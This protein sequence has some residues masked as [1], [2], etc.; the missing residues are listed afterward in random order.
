MKKVFKKRTKHL[1]SLFLSMVMILST[2]SVTA[3]AANN[4]CMEIK[5]GI[6]F[7][8]SALANN[9]VLDIHAISKSNGA[10]AEI[11]SNN[12]GLNQMYYISKRGDHY[13]IIALHSGK[14]IDVYGASKESGTNVCQ[15]E[16]N[17]SDIAE[18]WDIID[19]GNGYV[20]F[21]SVLG[22][23]LDVQ[24]GEV[25]DGA[26]VWAHRWNGS[27]A[28]QWLL[29]P[30]K[31]VSDVYDLDIQAPDTISIVPGES[32]STTIQFSG[33]GIRDFHCSISG[34]GL[35]GKIAGSKWVSYPGICSVTVT[36]NAS[37]SFQ[38]ATLI[39]HLKSDNGGIL[40]TKKINVVAAPAR[41]RE[42]TLPMNIEL[43]KQTGKQSVSGP[44]F[45]YALSYA[46][47]ILDE[48]VHYW[49]EYDIY[50]GS[51]GQSGAYASRALAG[52]N[53]GKE[54]NNKSKVFEDVY[55]NLKDGKPVVLNVSGGRSSGEHFVC[56]VGYTGVTNPKNLSEFN[57][58]IIDSVG[59][60]PYQPE[61]LG[62]LKY[63]LKLCSGG[64]YYYTV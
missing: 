30:V 57:F 60:S 35:S 5:E 27:K 15:W 14:A 7:I 11:C 12:G 16:A 4:D 31:G 6:Y 26:N 36:L 17:A 56:V 48:R 20:Y 23:Y 40:E 44:C 41:D 18:Q 47:D 33:S 32:A 64:Y 29:V 62:A 55:Y 63:N 28:Q 8:Q 50:K 43:L 54:T 59:G 38:N 49:T 25:R 51:H 46:R 45:C 61:N 52:F 53:R 19:A 10:S 42:F 13:I 22:T 34:S 9:M 24:N 37:K 39:F 58:L 21:R 2:F 1:V 3:F